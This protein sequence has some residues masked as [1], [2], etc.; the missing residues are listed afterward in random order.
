MVGKTN[1]ILSET[2]S[3]TVRDIETHWEFSKNEKFSFISFDMQIILV[4]TR[5]IRGRHSVASTESVLWGTGQVS[6]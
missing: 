3:F 6:K 5:S 2:K 4:S 1:C